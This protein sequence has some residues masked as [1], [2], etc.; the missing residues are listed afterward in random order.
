MKRLITFVLCL[1]MICTTSS[2][3]AADLTIPVKMER[4]MQHDGNGLKG[5]FTIHANADPEKDP[6]LFAVQNAEYS[7]LRNAS[8]DSWHLVMFQTDDSEQQRN[9]SELYRT[10]DALYFRSDFLP[11][12]VYVISA[13]ALFA[14]FLDVGKGDNP[15]LMPAMLSMITM[16]ESSRSGWE[17]IASKYGKMLEIWLGGFA[18]EPELTY[19][20]EGTAQMNLIYEVP[21]EDVCQE[22]VT[23]VTTAAADPDVSAWIDA[24][25]TPEEKDVYL[26]PYLAEFYLDALKN[27][28]IFGNIRFVKTVTALGEMIS[29]EISIPLSSAITGYSTLVIVNSNHMISYTLSG[30]SQTLRL[31]IPEDLKELTS[32]DDYN[33]TAWLIRHSSSDE[34][35]NIAYQIDL[36]RTTEKSYDEETAKEHEIHRYS[37]AASVNTDFLPETISADMFAHLEP[38]QADLEFHYSGKTGPNAPVTLGIAAQIIRGDLNISID[39]K[40]KTSSTW[41]FVPFSVEQPVPVSSFKKE[42]IS[43][44]VDE[45]V[46]HAVTGVQ[47]LGGLDSDMQIVEGE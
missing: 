45:W 19:N 8:G 43:E 38:I 22:I 47:R 40:I 11:D 42:V 18:R 3:F 23:L 20:S 34:T 46:Q 41:P 21:Y 28:Q 29:T 16:N 33:F 24:F 31:I 35:L 44:Y 2:S 1:M 13:E 17:T 7:L 6:V 25:I 26:N 36:K 4:Q 39:G 37:I 9:R 10:K 27:L 32:S 5:S 30:D 14:T 15:S 12:H